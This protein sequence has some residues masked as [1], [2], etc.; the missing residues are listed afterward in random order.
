MRMSNKEEMNEGLLLLNLIGT[1]LLFRK[2]KPDKVMEIM[3]ILLTI[4]E[5]IDQRPTSFIMLKTEVMSYCMRLVFTASI[6]TYK[7][8]KLVIPIYKRCYEII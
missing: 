5:K 2:N 6:K 8:G 4:S 3:P 7:R 1:T